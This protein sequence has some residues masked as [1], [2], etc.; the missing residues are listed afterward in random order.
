MIEKEIG[1]KIHAQR[2]ALGLTL[3]EV[4][5]RVHVARS[6]IQRYEAGNIKNIKMPV[7]SSIAQALEISPDWLI[8]K[9]SVSHPT[10]HSASSPSPALTPAESILLA[11]FRLLND[12][13]QNEA[14]FLIRHLAETDEYKKSPAAG[15]LPAAR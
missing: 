11:D 13:G 15:V 8:G 6:T 12:R 3:Q 7:L 14:L 5:D 4:A 2:K 1:A 9:S 10:G